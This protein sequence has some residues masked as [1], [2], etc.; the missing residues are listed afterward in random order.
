MK[1]LIQKFFVIILMILPVFS[2]T[3]KQEKT[4]RNDFSAREKRLLKRSR[5]LMAE[6]YF[7]TLVT[8]ND[9]GELRTRIMEPLPPGK[10][11]TVWMATNKNSRKVKEIKTNPGATLFYFARNVP[12]YVSLYGHAYI[13]EDKETKDSMWQQIW[14]KYYPGKKNYALIKFIPYRLEMIDP[15]QGLPG[16]SLTWKPYTVVLRR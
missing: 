10:N 1:R 15:S 5:E 8:T 14:E 4:F 2:C 3:V 6:S 9:K 7:A 12:G 13:V 16:D 11:F